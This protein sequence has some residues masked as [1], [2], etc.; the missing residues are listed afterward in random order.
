MGAVLS[1]SF[2][3]VSTALWHHNNPSAELEVPSALGWKVL[4]AL[5]ANG[6]DGVKASAP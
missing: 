1:G 5:A 6:I 4:C 3:I 2:M